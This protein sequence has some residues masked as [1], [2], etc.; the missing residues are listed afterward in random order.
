M[1]RNNLFMKKLLILLF[2]IFTASFSFAAEQR[3]TVPTE[4]SPYCGTQNA[5][6]TIIEFLD[7]Q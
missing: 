7:Y 1:Q 2:V 4:D 3:Y 5:P 6:V